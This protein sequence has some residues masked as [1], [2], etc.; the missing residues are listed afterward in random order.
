LQL[1]GPIVCAL[2]GRQGDHIVTHTPDAS[3]ILDGNPHRFFFGWCYDG[4]PHMNHSARHNNV[5]AA[6]HNA[7]IDQC[8]LYCMFDCPIVDRW[9]R[10]SL[11]RD[12]AVKEVRTANDANH[13]SRSHYWDT[14]DAMLFKE[15]GDG[16][17]GRVFVNRDDSAGHHVT[18]M[19]TVSFDV[20]AG[21][22]F[23]EQDK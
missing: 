20:S 13:N 5:E 3:R 10:A 7:G 2:I 16:L 4:S 8:L 12:K 15:V 19:S 1:Y 11:S 14:L 18:S 22:L 21:L 17:Q 9:I 23:G 6:A